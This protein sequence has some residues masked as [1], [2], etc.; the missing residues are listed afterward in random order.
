MIGEK[1]F[2]VVN[3]LTSY[4][5]DEDQNILKGGKILFQKKQG[6]WNELSEKLDILIYLA[7]NYQE[8]INLE[9]K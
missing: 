5:N 6:A 1:Q 8:H 2:G 3:G 7:S 4:H 9:L